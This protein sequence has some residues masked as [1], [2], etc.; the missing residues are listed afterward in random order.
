MTFEQEIA[1]IDNLARSCRDRAQANDLLEQ[2]VSLLKQDNASLTATLESLTAVSKRDE[3]ELYRV[4]DT[5]NV[6]VRSNGELK[7]TLKQLLAEQMALA[8]RAAEM[9][10]SLEEPAPTLLPQEPETIKIEQP[11]LSYGDAHLLEKHINKTLADIGSIPAGRTF[12]LDA[13]Y[14]ENISDWILKRWYKRILGKP[15]LNFRD[16]PSVELRKEEGGRWTFLRQ[17]PKLTNKEDREP[18]PFRKENEN[19]NGTI[20]QTA[21]PPDDGQELPKFLIK[22]NGTHDDDQG[23][24][25]SDI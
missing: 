11:S 13:P 14:G 12:T 7:A 19:G 17:V 8:G 3:A 21:F 9:L 18:I 25:A 16:A 23:R 22:P 6:E 24:K 4:R 2:E 1:A 10:R 5:L 20:K 15:M